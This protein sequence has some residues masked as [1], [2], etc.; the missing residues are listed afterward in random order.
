MIM[1]KSNIVKKFPYPFPENTK[2]KCMDY[3]IDK[4]K[5]YLNFL[6]AQRKEHYK[7]FL[8]NQ[9]SY[10]TKNM[11]KHKKEICPDHLLTFM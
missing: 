8:W 2:S 7:W 10:V 5:S 6:K 9:C 3:F 11:K 4:K 1:E